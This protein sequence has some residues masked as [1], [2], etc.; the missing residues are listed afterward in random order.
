MP[1]VDYREENALLLRE[2]MCR[3]CGHQRASIV[4]RNRAGVVTDVVCGDCLGKDKPATR[5]A[6]VINFKHKPEPG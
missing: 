4:I 6:F 3:R 2:S 5:P 1:T